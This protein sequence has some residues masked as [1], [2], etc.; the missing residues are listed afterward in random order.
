M[1]MSMSEMKAKYFII[2]RKLRSELNRDLTDDDVKGIL[3][4]TG[5]STDIGHTSTTMKIDI[6][7][8]LTLDHYYMKHETVKDITKMT[9]MTKWRLN[10]T[11]SSF[12]CMVTQYF[13]GSQKIY[14]ETTDHT[15]YDDMVYQWKDEIIEVTR[16]ID[17]LEKLNDV[18]NMF[19]Y[20]LS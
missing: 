11:R 6:C 7:D 15:L 18:I 17:N 4:Y 9:K 10:H 13:I 12:S 16:S 8:R 5:E 14:E 19:R 3:K 1:S 2:G 20:Q